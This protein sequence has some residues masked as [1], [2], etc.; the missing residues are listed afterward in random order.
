MGRRW[1]ASQKPGGEGLDSEV[2]VFCLSQT[3]KTADIQILPAGAA[4]NQPMPHLT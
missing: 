3:S 4:N 1:N 2:P